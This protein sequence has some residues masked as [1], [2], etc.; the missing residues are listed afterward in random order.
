MVS[1]GTFH[2]N[3]S[4]PAHHVPQ[5][6]IEVKMTMSVL[7]EEVKQGTAAL[8]GMPLPNYTISLYGHF[9]YTLGLPRSYIVVIITY[10]QTVHI[11]DTL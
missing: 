9:V 1:V 6:S 5:S 4:S 10:L 8:M 2:P 11:K 3:W 7:S